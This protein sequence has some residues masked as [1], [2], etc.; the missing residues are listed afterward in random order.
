MTPRPPSKLLMAA[1]LPRALF[2]AAELVAKA[3]RLAR[4]PRGDGRPVVILPGLVNPDWANVAMRLYLRRLGYDARGWGLGPNLGARSVGRDAE[5]LD[6]LVHR[7]FAE[8][9]Q[10]VTLVGISLGGIMARLMAHRWPGEVREVITISSPFAGD[11]R[12]TNVWR[13]F[14][15]LSGE[16]VDDEQVRANRALVET[17]PPVP[18]TAIWSASDGLVQG[19]ICRTE[20]CR[21]IEVRSGHVWVQMRAEVLLAVAQALGGE[22]APKDGGSA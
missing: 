21:S 6:A 12:A 11:P 4:A 16:R 18:T 8:T 1:E 5:R 17:E 19:R 2:G 9:G 10:K 7:V 20:T 13:V 22:G 3:P 14:E 15:W